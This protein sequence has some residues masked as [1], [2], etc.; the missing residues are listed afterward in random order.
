M[1]ATPHMLAGA[2][3]GK[4]LRRPYLALPAAFASHFV[5]D[6]VPHSDTYSLFGVH[7]LPPTHLVI[8][9]AALDAAVGIAL[10]LWL[11]RG[12]PNRTVILWAAFFGILTDL[13]DNVPGVMG[14]FHQI[15]GALAFSHFH[16]GIQHNVPRSEWVLGLGTQVPVVAGAVYVLLRRPT[17]G[18][19]DRD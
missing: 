17:A 13:L 2:A 10:V 1:L 4:L 6:M 9:M 19:A 16:H 12:Q 3:I 18:A 7:G 5:L 8:G 15:P 14:V 11:S